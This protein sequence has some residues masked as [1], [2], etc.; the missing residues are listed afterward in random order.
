LKA[1]AH[2]DYKHPN[3]N[4]AE[5]TTAVLKAL[6]ENEYVYDAPPAPVRSKNSVFMKFEMDFD[7]TDKDLFE[8]DIRTSLVNSGVENSDIKDIHFTEG[9]VN[10]ELTCIDDTVAERVEN[11]VKGGLEVDY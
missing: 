7:N 2:T 1:L 9:S 4:L 6:H 10:A 5:F 8:Q 3:M 11:L